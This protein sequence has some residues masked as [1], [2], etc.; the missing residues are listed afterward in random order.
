MY[1]SSVETLE[2]DS[3]KNNVGSTRIHRLLC[4]YTSSVVPVLTSRN[5]QS[6]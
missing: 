4:V 3:T 1:T 2:L 6:L 5:S